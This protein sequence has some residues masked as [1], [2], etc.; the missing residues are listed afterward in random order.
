MRKLLILLAGCVIGAI[1][2]VFALRQEFQPYQASSTLPEIPVCG[3][4]PER[5]PDNVVSLRVS[6][7]ANRPGTVCIRVYNGTPEFWRYESEAL[8]VERCWFGLVCFPPLRWRFPNM[9]LIGGVVL[10]GGGE[11]MLFPGYRDFH[12]SLSY[13]P[14]SPGT[15]RIRFRYFSSYEEEKQTVYSEEF[16]LP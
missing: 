14:T 9:P 6:R 1:L 13:E 4:L 11:Y 8:Q 3:L 12:R 16:V 7:I 10:L 2:S 15:Y 5:G